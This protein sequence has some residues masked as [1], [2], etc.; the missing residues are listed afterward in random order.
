MPGIRVVVKGDKVAARKLR[1]LNPKTNPEFVRRAL[2]KGG[3]LIQQDAQLN[4]IE[5]GGKGPPLPHRLTSRTG[6]GRRSI[7]VDRGGLPNFFID[8]G[9]DLEYMQLH[10]LTPRAYLAP[11][12]EAVDD[13]LENLFRLEWSRESSR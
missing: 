6:T 1:K 7:R 9:S 10:E 2:V 12:I 5:R 11:A 3:F 13:K 4:Q 8:I